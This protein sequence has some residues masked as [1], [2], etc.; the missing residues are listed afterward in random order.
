MSA[1]D[2]SFLLRASVLITRRSREAVEKSG[3]RETAPARGME[4]KERD[5]RGRA[6]KGKEDVGIDEGEW[7]FE[8][9]SPAEGGSF[10]RGEGG[11]RGRKLVARGATRRQSAAASTVGEGRTEVLINYSSHR[12]QGHSSEGPDLSWPLCSRFAAR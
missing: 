12:R 1:G 6:S 3:E 4:K 5:K 2:F 7:Y 11:G 10:S 9:F 8:W